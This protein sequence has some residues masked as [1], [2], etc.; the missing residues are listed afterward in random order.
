MRCSEIMLK[1]VS[2]PCINYKLQADWYLGRIP[3]EVILTFVGFG[4]SK[5]RNAVFMKNIVDKTGVGAL[6]VDLSGH[7]ESNFD[8]N[9]TTPLQHISEAVMAYD[10]IKAEYP[11]SKIHVIGTSY[12]GFIASY[13]TRFRKVSKVVLRTPAIYKPQL[14]CTKHKDIDKTAVRT[15]R[16]DKELVS[17]HPLFTHPAISTSPTLLIIHSE[18]KSVPVQTTDVYREK[19]NADVY[20]AEGFA[21][22][23]RDPSNPRDGID[24]YYEAI[25]NHFLL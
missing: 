13:L 17:K 25:S 11:K 18:D 23:F 15:Y 21:H 1:Q 16:S 4:S 6:V 19:F 10:W 9:E 3:D 22:S 7:G 12:G 2:I 24:A 8:I 14:L 5:E 20:T